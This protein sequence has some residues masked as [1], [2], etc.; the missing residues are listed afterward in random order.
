[1]VEKLVVLWVQMKEYRL[2]LKGHSMVDKMV[3]KTVETTAD[4]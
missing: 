1:M 4:Q 3:E 2:D